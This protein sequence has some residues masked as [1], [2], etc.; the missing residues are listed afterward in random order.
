MTERA[1]GAEPSGVHVVAL[2]TVDALLGRIVKRARLVAILADEFGVLAEQWEARQIVVESHVVRP[3]ELAVA[4]YAIAPELRLVRI[5]LEM[6]A[7]ALR[8]RQADGDRFEMAGHALE[9][10]VRA[11][12]QEFRVARVI[13]LDVEPF[14]HPMATGALGAVDAVVGVVL[15]MAGHALCVEFLLE[16]VARMT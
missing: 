9:R 13:E 3:R 4:S 10:G 7:D 6:T 14:R 15:T 12:E 1:V 5:I 8:L 2:V 11:V 16:L